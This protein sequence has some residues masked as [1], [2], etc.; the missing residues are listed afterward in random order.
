MHG[1]VA[2]KAVLHMRYDGAVLDSLY[3]HGTIA[4]REVLHAHGTVA[5]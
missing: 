1:T 5:T 2:M 4:K 3:M